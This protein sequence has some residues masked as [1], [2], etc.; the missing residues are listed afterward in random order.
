MEMRKTLRRQRATR[1]SNFG[2]MGVFQI[3]VDTCRKVMSAPVRRRNARRMRLR[4]LPVPKK[5]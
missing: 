3:V 4:R 5:K 2:T 1:R